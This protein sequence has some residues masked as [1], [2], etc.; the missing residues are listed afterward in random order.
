MY[1]HYLELLLAIHGFHFNPSSGKH[2]IPP[3]RNNG[4]QTGKQTNDEK[5]G[6]EFPNNQPGHKRLRIL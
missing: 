5:I 2:L 4:C 1:L 3:W 6:K